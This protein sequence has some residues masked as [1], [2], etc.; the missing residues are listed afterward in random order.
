MSILLVHGGGFAGSCW[1]RLLPHLEE[2]AFGI[3]LPGRGANPADLATLRSS[4][5][6]DAVVAAIERLGDDVLLVGHSL[7]G[8]T[9]PRV[10]ARVGE[11]LRRVV[12]VSCTVPRTGGTVIDALSGVE[13]GSLGELDL[14]TVSEPAPGGIEPVLDPE[15]AR[16]LFCNDMDEATT[17]YTLSLMVPEARTVIAEP[18]DTS[19]VALPLPKT[20]VRLLDDAV[21]TLDR[22]DTTIA[23]IPEIDVVDLPAAHM[24]MITQ[25]EGLAAILNAL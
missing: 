16:M 3:D 25:P 11:R 13:F 21:L 14:S 22:Q 23:R 12:F 17:Q 24:A 2:E 9:L 10:M 18:I 6:V 7:A 8:I 19:G 4:S 20:W 1:D 5:S 15:L